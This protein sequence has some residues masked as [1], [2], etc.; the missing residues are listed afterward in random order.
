M[1]RGPLRGRKSSLIWE[2]HEQPGS[3]NLK[4]DLGPAELQKATSNVAKSCCGRAGRDD[5]T[6][7]A[8]STFALT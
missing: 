7:D 5:A 8:L 1:P 3:S 2:I 6:L 4:V